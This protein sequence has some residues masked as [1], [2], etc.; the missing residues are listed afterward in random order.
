M[1]SLPK[2]VR[3]DVLRKRSWVAGILYYFYLARIVLAVLAMGVV[4]LV[5]IAVG[6]NGGI[7]NHSKSTNETGC[8]QHIDWEKVQACQQQGEAEDICIERYKAKC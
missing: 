5:V 6:L 4:A 8:Y 1:K 3:M 7:S 2:L